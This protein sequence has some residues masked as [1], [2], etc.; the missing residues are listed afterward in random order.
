MIC[1][2]TLPLRNPD[3]D[4]VRDRPVG[5]VEILAEFLGGDLDRELHGVGRGR[6]DGR[7]HRSPRLLDTPLPPRRKLLVAFG[8]VFEEEL[9]FA[10]ELADRA[11][12]IS[13]SYFLGEFE[14]QKPDSSP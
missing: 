6:L 5:A 3:L 13:M 2:G 11:G 1:F 10:H 12:E 9:S 14:A 7:L 8:P 4:L